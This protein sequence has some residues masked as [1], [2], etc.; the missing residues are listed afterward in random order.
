MIRRHSLEKLRAPPIVLG[1]LRVADVLVVGLSAWLSFVIRHGVAD[2]PFGYVVVTAIGALITANMLHAA[3]LYVFEDLTKL[4]IQVY[5][6]SMALPAVLL[7]LLAFGFFTKTSDEFSR[8]WAAGW[9][10]LSFV[11]IVGLRTF[12]AMRLRVW[13][14]RGWL[15]RNLVIIGAGE[16]GRR[17]VH[18]LVATD[19]PGVRLLGLFD[20]RRSRVP[21]EIEGYRVLGTVDDLP[22]FTRAH[23]VDEIVIALPWDNMAR[24]DACMNRLRSVAANVQLCPDTVGFRLYNRGVRHLAGVPMLSVSEL[25][26]SGWSQV[27]KA[28]EDRLIAAFL[29]A[30]VSPLLAVIALAIRLEGPGPILFRQRR[31]GFNNEIITVYKFRTMQPDCARADEARQATR[32][33]PRVTRVGAFLRRH[34]L[35]ELPQLLN[36]LKGEM[37]LVGPRP[38]AVAHNEQYARLIDGYLGRHKVKPGITGWAQVNGLRGETETVDKMEARVRH[39]I[40]YIDNWSLLF[41]LRILLLTL[42][43]GFR[44]E[45]AY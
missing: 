19:E 15:R 22:G 34:S 27:V 30:L 26:L 36:V 1:V 8:L 31:Y 12:V 44:S 25:P 3:R 33:D 14:R 24:L 10:G 29:L 45:N 21:D 43:V 18:H 35:D 41:D 9:F 32:D 17:L 5:R 23:R 38:H 40:Y 7:I 37:S 42:F 20:D 6:L 39:D 16:V 28:M 4:P 11:G 2:W 13:Q